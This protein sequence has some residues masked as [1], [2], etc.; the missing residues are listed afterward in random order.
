[1][2]AARL[3]LWLHVLST[4]GVL[5][6]TFDPVTTTVVIGIGATLGRT[7]YNYLHESCDSKWI[8]FNAT[9]LKADLDSKLFGQHLASRII[10]K[11]VN[12]FVSSDNPKKP[13][14]LSLHGST[15]TGKNFVSKLI[16]ENIYKEGMDSN[17]VHVFTATLHFPHPSQYLNMYKYQ[18]QQWIKGNVTNCER[19][20]FIFDEMD[21]MHPGL[22]DSIK[23]YLDYYDKLDGI[24]YR[25]A[26]FIFLSNAGG[27]N[28]IQTTLDFWK[29]GRTREEIKLKDLETLLS[30]SVFN[31]NQSGFF[32]TSLIDKNLVDFF[33]PFLP[34]EYEHVVQCA[35]AEMEARGLPP[36][37]HVANRMA[38]DLVYSPK[39]ER[40]FSVKGCKTIESK[41]N[42]YI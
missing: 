35:M 13:L 11:A 37:R 34:L 2:N 38:K 5:V 40:I 21:K 7:I 32:R 28:I 26:I 12:G 3:Y 31:N 17:F 1:M 18:L 39:T 16:A 6:N 14:V 15:G 30:L 4:T 19:S 23:P 25:K 9:G 8:A 10:F 29:S 33:V 20:M 24:S 36:N 41:L 27:D 22:I 42:Y